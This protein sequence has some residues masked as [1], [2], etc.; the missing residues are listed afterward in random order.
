MCSTNQNKS[1]MLIQNLDYKQIRLIRHLLSPKIRS[2]GS[3][4]RFDSVFHTQML[5]CPK[6]LLKRAHRLIWMNCSN[7]MHPK[8]S[9][10]YKRKNNAN[11]ID[12][13]FCRELREMMEFYKI[14]MLSLLKN[15]KEPKK[16]YLT[17]W[18]NTKKPKVKLPLFRSDLS[19]V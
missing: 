14:C 9:K 19:R 13:K 2:R 6:L 4:S 16:S 3:K 17:W 12:S 7:D 10:F 15:D 1:S 8:W 18:N 11:K 5:K